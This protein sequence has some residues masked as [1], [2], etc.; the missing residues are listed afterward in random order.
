MIH[1]PTPAHNR[2][3][4]SPQLTLPPALQISAPAVLGTT[5]GPCNRRRMAATA[6]AGCGGCSSAGGQTPAEARRGGVGV[7][8]RVLPALSCPSPGAATPR[9]ALG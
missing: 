9:A 3:P 1:S 6:K 7:L 4:A 5:R 8:N 2:Q